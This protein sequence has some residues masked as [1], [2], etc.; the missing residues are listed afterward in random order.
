[1]SSTLPALR[2]SNIYVSSLLAGTKWATSS[3]TYS[4][5]TS[6]A[7]YGV[8][9]G[10][11]EPSNAFGTF[12]SAQQGAARTALKLY[13][14]VANLTFHE[15]TETASQHADIRFAR[16]NSPWTAWA[17]YPNDNDTGGDVW[18]NNTSRTYDAPRKGN[19]AYLTI[20]HEIGHALG[21][22]HPHEGTAMPRNRDS[23]EYTIMSYRSHVG[24]SMSSGYTNETW[25]Y[26]QS[27]MMYDI[28]ALQHL[29]GANYGTNSGNTVYA[30]TPTGRAYVNGS[31]VSVAGDNRI[32]QTLWDGGGIDTYDFRQYTTDLKINL[33]PGSWTLTSRSQLAKLDAGGKKLAA[34]NIANAFLYEND[35][36]SLIEK[37]LGGS[38]N[39]TITGN[40]GANTLRGN[41]GNDRLVGRSGDDVLVGGSGNDTLYGDSG[42]DRLYGGSGADIFRFRAV[43][44]SLSSARDTIKDFERGVDIID[45]RS[46]DANTNVAGNQAFTFIGRA[47]FKGAAG[48]LRFSDGLLSADVNGD[49]IADMQVNVARLTMLSKSDFYL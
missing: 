35:T 17:Y 30:W 8:S 28:A 40:Q 41:A 37:A 29:Y 5:P 3:L 42:A 46:I 32:F 23:M 45:L 2:P 16:S 34:G 48:E 47:A 1:M 31:A 11:S 27:L 44:D 36:R 21:L 26:S 39:D 18:V 13:A 14:S 33:N 7:H 38:G 43:S 4:F 10:S 20:A 9:Y 12:L 19:Y 49:A 6:S 25:G 15:I 22:E 24:A